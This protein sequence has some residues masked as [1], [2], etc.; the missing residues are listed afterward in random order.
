MQAGGGLRAGHDLDA[1]LRG[2]QAGHSGVVAE[3]GGEG[4]LEGIGLEDLV[5][6]LKQRAAGGL[7]ARRKHDSLHTALVVERKRLGYLRILT[8]GRVKGRRGGFARLRIAGSDG[9]ELRIGQRRGGGGGFGR[10]RHL[11]GGNGLLHRVHADGIAAGGAQERAQHVVG[12]LSVRREIKRGVAVVRLQGGDEGRGGGGVG[13][14]RGRGADQADQLVLGQAAVRIIAHEQGAVLLL[15]GGEDGLAVGGIGGGL[16]KDGQDVVHRL[17]DAANL[18]AVKGVEH[19]IAVGVDD[20]HALV[21][22]VDVRHPAAREL[23]DLAGIKRDALLVAGD[24]LAREIDAVHPRAGV[25]HA[26]RAAAVDE[27]GGIQV[28]GMLLRLGIRGDGQPG[29]GRAG[30]ERGHPGE[31]VV[32]V[33]VIAARGARDVQAHGLCAAHQLGHLRRVGFAK[34]LR[35]R[36]SRRRAIGIAG[37]GLDLDGLQLPVAGGQAACQRAGRESQQQAKREDTQNVFHDGSSFPCA[38]VG[39]AHSPLGKCNIIFIACSAKKCKLCT[40]KITIRG[41]T[42]GAKFKFR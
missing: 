33:G 38:D 7:R 1:V 15:L 2:D 28:E 42:G 37:Q 9:L 31:G 11:A 22:A 35:A 41:L 24:R 3:G 8:G 34:R 40:P 5:D 6:R 26:Q 4:I 18:V 20:H 17:R 12:E 25:A 21:R 36:L 30:H 16:R 27:D 19:H 32:R 13:L 29:A 39:T 10:E 23:V 14:A